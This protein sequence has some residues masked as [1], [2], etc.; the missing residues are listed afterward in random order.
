V[1]KEERVFSFCFKKRTKG[2]RSNHAARSERRKKE[3]K[4]QTFSYRAFGGAMTR[5]ADSLRRFLNCGPEV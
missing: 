5:D 1:K 2:T 4:K 3:K